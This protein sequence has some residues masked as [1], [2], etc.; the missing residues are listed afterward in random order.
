MVIVD[1]IGHS[2]EV[3]AAKSIAQRGVVMVR[4]QQPPSRLVTGQL[5]CGAARHDLR[6]HRPPHAMAPRSCQLAESR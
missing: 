1:E 4:P 6:C 3:A 2:K 5:A